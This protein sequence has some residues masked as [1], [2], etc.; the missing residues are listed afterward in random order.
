LAE[1][2]LEYLARVGLLNL[3]IKL[4]KINKFN[5]FY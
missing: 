3:M 4:K 1:L 5:K 2:E